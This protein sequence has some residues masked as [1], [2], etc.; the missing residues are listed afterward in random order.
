MSEVGEGRKLNRA[1]E[2]TFR[3][4]AIV[5]AD[6]RTMLDSDFVP[7]IPH[8]SQG[9]L[10]AAMCV[11]ASRQR[12]MPTARRGTTGGAVRMDI[13]YGPEVN[14]D[15]VAAEGTTRRATSSEPAPLSCDDTAPLRTEWVPSRLS[16]DAEQRILALYDEYRPRLNRYLR[17]LNLRRDWI[18]EVIQETFMRLT[19]KLIRKDNIDSMEAWVIRVS[20]NLAMDV[21][22]KERGE[23]TN[24]DTTAFLI[25]NHAD[26]SLTPEEAYSQNE[27]SVQMKLA[28]SELKPQQR[29]CFEM[30]A[31]GFRYK[32][33]ALALGI[34]EQRAAF[35][36]KQ[37]AVHLAA[38]YG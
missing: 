10:A 16:D 12:L 31:H 15:S 1:A 2:Q 28:M 8:F 27:Q 5:T 4:S 18:E 20:H 30:R 14:P 7:S 38:I 26:P 17:T 23:I 29:Q 9:E 32:D 21:L 13:C 37:V 3:V 35:V 19:I 25:K 24:D 22:K 11:G 6:S 33:I 34:S 36:V